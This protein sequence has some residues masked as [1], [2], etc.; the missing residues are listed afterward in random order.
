MACAICEVR[1]PRRTC[2]GVGGEICSICCG[3]EREVTVY[4]PLD[5]DYLR[6]ARKH[7]RPVPVDPATAGDPDIR[8]TEDM[9]EK[10]EVLL[11]FLAE[12]LVGAALATPGVVDF[13]IREALQALIRTCRTLASGLYYQSVPQNPLAAS[14]FQALDRGLEEYRKRE[15][16]ELGMTRTRDSD[17]LAMLVFLERM[18]LD[19]N[20]GRRRGRAF[21]DYLRQSYPNV[22]SAPSGAAFS[23]L[24]IS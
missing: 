9:L 21:L 2:P 12:R 5:C 4:C 6:D 11:E 20:N 1:R 23:P 8:I 7:D 3:T 13:D 17:V 24:V 18:E 15:T 10:N 16:A 19:R 14:L 22:A